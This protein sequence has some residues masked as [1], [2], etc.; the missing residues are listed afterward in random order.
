MP[1]AG[2]EIRALISRCLV[3]LKTCLRPRALRMEI[4]DTQSEFPESFFV[5]PPAMT[6]DIAVPYHPCG[7][8]EFFIETALQD[9]EQLDNSNWYGRATKDDF[10]EELVRTDPPTAFLAEIAGEECPRARLRDAFVRS[11]EPVLDILPFVTEASKPLMQIH[12]VTS[13]TSL[14]K[15]KDWRYSVIVRI[16]SMKIRENPPPPDS[17][18]Y[19]TIMY[20]PCYLGYTA[21]QV[22]ISP[23]SFTNH[24]ESWTPDADYGMPQLLYTPEA[25]QDLHSRVCG[26][27]QACLPPPSRNRNPVASSGG[28]APRTI[29]KQSAPGV[30]GKVRHDPYPQ[31]CGTQARGAAIPPHRPGKKRSAQRTDPRQTRPVLSSRVPPR[32]ARRRETSPPGARPRP[33]R[34]VLAL[35]PVTV[36]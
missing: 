15:I 2:R 34:A 18:L 29:P 10:V 3:G 24:P 9:R 28:T 11:V 5:F 30:R 25:L 33:Q 35:A 6:V 1:Y 26:V 21:E 36:L 32:T 14:V 22:L 12:H 16:I 19:P 20:A 17:L 13:I 31:T 7:E 23:G 27:N 8:I 4:E